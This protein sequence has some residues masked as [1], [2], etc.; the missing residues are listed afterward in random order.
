MAFKFIGKK[1]RMTKLFDKRGKAISCSVI[2]IHPHVVCQIKDKKKDGYNA[3]QLGAFETLKNV[4]KPLAFHFSKNGLKSY[5]YLAESK[6]DDVDR[7]KLGQ[8]IKAF[9]DIESREYK[10]KWFTEVKIWKA[11]VLGSQVE[12]QTNQAEEIKEEESDDLPF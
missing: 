8:E 4:T 3:L 12:Q 10:E 1:L 6:I 7:Y 9:L 2:E 5:K 11:E